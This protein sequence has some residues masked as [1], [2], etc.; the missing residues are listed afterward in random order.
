MSLK[1]PPNDPLASKPPA[2]FAEAA[3][4]AGPRSYALRFSGIGQDVV[5]LGDLL[6]PLL[7]LLV[8]LV[9]VRVVLA[10]ELP[11]GLLDLL[12]GGVLADPQDLVVVGL[13]SHGGLVYPATTTRAGRITVSPSA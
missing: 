5:G 13:V 9:A 12:V 8:A 3:E 7:G 1:P 4:R 10:R 2:M 11:V 6:E